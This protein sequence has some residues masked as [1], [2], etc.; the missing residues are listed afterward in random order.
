MKS[1]SWIN[2]M[3]SSLSLPR[4]GDLES[5]LGRDEVVEVL[6][7]FGDVDLPPLDGALEA[8]LLRG[9]VVADG[10][11]RVRTDVARLVGREDHRNRDFDAALAGPGGLGEDTDRAALAE[12]AAVVVELHA[13]LMGGGRNRGVALDVEL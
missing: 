1:R 5:L 7:G 13:H 3:H 2:A 10:R 8:A 6:G 12:A 11:G 9:V 4:H